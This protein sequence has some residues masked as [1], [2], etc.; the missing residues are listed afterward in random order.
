ME[1]VCR[2]ARRARIRVG[3]CRAVDAGRTPFT[4][5]P[6]G[7]NVRQCS[8]NEQTVARRT[9]C[10]SL[11]RQSSTRIIAETSRRCPESSRTLPRPF[12][13]RAESARRLPSVWCPVRNRSIEASA[14]AISAPR[15]DG[16]PHRRPPMSSLR[17]HWR[18]CTKPPTRHGWPVAAATG[19]EPPSAGCCELPLVPDAM[20]H[21]ASIT[22]IPLLPRSVAGRRLVSIRAQRRRSQLDAALA[23]GADPWSAPEL[24][25]RASRLGSLSQRRKIAAGLHALVAAATHR[26]RASPFVGV[27]D[28]VVLEQR[29]SLVA[30][31]E[32][33]FQPAPVK[34]AVV[35][36]LALL[37]SDPSSPAYAGGRDPGSFAAVTT[38]CLHSVS[39]DG[40]SD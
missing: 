22:G 17:Q 15:R 14:A 18:V 27:R 32:R 31:A 11:R 7:G 30:L 4:R 35:A 23:Q 21:A 38:R 34:V 26:R 29:E 8:Q 24:M 36:Q 25:V 37:L 16:R 9:I 12:E 6:R 28:R 2:R 33:L 19:P 13:P 1:I 40:A 39:E 20:S 5:R 3:P 10:W